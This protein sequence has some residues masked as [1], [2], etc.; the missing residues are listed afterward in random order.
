M[1]HEDTEPTV[2]LPDHR[3]QSQ[4]TLWNGL[5]KREE[6]FW[7]SGVVR[8]AEVLRVRDGQRSLCFQR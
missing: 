3:A 5:E 6:V 4:K 7:R 2:D 1:F 8:S